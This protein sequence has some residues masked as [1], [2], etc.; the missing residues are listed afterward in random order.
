MLITNPVVPKKISLA[1][2][3]KMAKNAQNRGQNS[4]KPVL[5]II[6][7]MFVDFDWKSYKNV[8]S[9]IS[10]HS[11][12]LIGPNGAVFNFWPIAALLSYSSNCTCYLHYIHQLLLKYNPLSNFWSIWPIWAP[13]RRIIDKDPV[14]RRRIHLLNLLPKAP[15]TQGLSGVD[16][17][18]IV[19]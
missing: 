2:V 14:W 1:K 19:F 10:D 13:R 12:P 15:H 4:Q 6:C 17:F 11:G 18:Q 16:C 8:I 7:L 3:A 5:R 9:M